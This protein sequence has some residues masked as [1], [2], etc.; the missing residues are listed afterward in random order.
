M[1]QDSSYLKRPSFQFSIRKRF[2]YIV[3]A[4]KGPGPNFP[5]LLDN[6][7]AYFR[8]EGPNGQ[9]IFGKTPS[10]DEEPDPRTLEIDY[11]YLEQTVHP[12]LAHRIPAFETVN[13]KRAW[14]GYYDYN[15]LDHNPIIGQDPY[16]S[17][18]IWAAGFT[19]R[20]LQMGPAVGRA[21][22]ELVLHDEFKTIDLSQ[23]G[24]DRF[25]ENRAL[26]QDIII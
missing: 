21:L 5:F 17:N 26:I 10:H 3:E 25:F 23:Y 24:W 7:G 13:V 16:Y 8:P 14:A 4:Q 22:M 1:T 18:L 19:G 2:A 9:Y 6:T 20:G 12:L 11:S 15:R